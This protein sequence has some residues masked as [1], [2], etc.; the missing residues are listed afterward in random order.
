M[1]SIIIYLFIFVSTITMISCEEIPEP[2]SIAP[3]IKYKN[4]KQFAISGMKQTIGRFEV[5]TSTLPLEFSIVNISETDGKDASALTEEVPVVI[6]TEA[7][8]GNESAEEL[9]M[10]TKTVMQPAV[11]VNQY[12]GQ[13]EI[14]EGNNITAGEYHFDIEISN[15]SGSRI[16]KDAIIIEFKEFDLISSSSGMAQKPVIERI[17]DTPNQILFVGHLNGEALHGNRIDFTKKRSEGFAGTFVNDTPEGEVW[18]V[19]FPVL[20]SKTY[21]TWKVI[22]NVGGV[23]TTS[24]VSEDFE[25]VLGRPGSYV[26]K[27]YK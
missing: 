14:L 16:L 24:F 17:G 7:I 19:D 20:E 8:D 12:T 1:K 9:A 6:Y 21:C 4:R 11:S 3:D 15:S 23:E 2:G 25:F 10:K 26:I 22:E 13:I 27:L 18:N 5:S